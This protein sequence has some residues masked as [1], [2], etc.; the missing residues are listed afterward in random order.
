L[1]IEQE[2]ANLFPPEKIYA[3]LN[4]LR[5]KLTQF[6]ER[7]GFGVTTVGF[8]LRCKKCDEPTFMINRRD[9]MNA[10]GLVPIDKRRNYRSSTRCGCPFKITYSRLPGRNQNNGSIKI[11]YSCIYK[12]GNGCV[13]SR[14]QLQDGLR[15]CGAYTRSIKESQIKTVLSVINTAE[16]VPARLMRKLLRPLFPPDHSLDAKFLLNFRMKAMNILVAKGDEVENMSFTA[17]EESNLLSNHCL[18]EYYSES[19][20]FYDKFMEKAELQPTDIQRVDTYL[21]S[22]AEVDGSFKYRRLNDANNSVTGYIWQTGVMRR[23][24]E[25]FGSTLFVDR[26]GRPLNNNGWPLMTIAFGYLWRTTP[27]LAEVSQ[28]IVF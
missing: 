22:L 11:T 2:A 8:S 3:S 6:G 27:I 4:D 12:H 14:S 28:N 10:S 9:R 21:Q 25:L 1:S 5:T 16:K 7:M 18:P 13:P 15:K 26:L 23:D 20:Q 24:F 17:E 19:F